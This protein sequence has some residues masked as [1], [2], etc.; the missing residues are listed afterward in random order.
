MNL[1]AQFEEYLQANPQA[2]NVWYD[3]DSESKAEC[4]AWLGKARTERGKR[5]RFRELAAHLSAIPS[6]AKYGVAADTAQDEIGVLA[7]LIDV[8]AK[9]LRKRR[10]GG[11]RGAGPPPTR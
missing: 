1:E 8:V 3:L 2:K 9:A 4:V 10:R 11:R 7:E 6:I 5:R